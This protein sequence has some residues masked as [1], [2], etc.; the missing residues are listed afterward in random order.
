M[1]GEGAA[2]ASTMA[3][4]EEGAPKTLAAAGTTAMD[5]G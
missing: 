1:T 2:T 5:G 3:G 4:E